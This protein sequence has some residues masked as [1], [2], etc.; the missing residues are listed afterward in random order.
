MERSRPFLFAAGQGIR[1][2][3]GQFRQSQKF[4]GVVDA[5]FHLFGR[6]AH[7]NGT[8]GQFFADTAAKELRIGMLPDVADALVKPFGI[9]VVAHLGRRNDRA[10]K[11]IGPELR[12]YK[13]VQQPQ[14]SICR[15][16]WAR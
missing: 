2:P 16:R 7:L 8:E 5:F 11:G 14:E 6:E 13:A 15:S 1:R 12:E 3:V 10:V 4:H 9:A